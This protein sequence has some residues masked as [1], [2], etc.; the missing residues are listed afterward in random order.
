MRAD[1][2][3]VQDTTTGDI[4]Q[5]GPLPLSPGF[6][7]ARTFGDWTT[8]GRYFV[9]GW[10]NMSRPDITETVLV[11]SATLTARQIL[12][13][14]PNREVLS[15]EVSPDGRTAYIAST[16][17][18]SAM[19]DLIDLPSDRLVFTTNRFSFWPSAFL[20][21]TSAPLPPEAL[22]AQVV[23]RSVRLTWALPPMSDGASPFFLEAGSRP[24]GTD[25]R[26]QIDGAARELDLA[27][28]P[29]G[30]YFVRLRAVNATG[31]SLPTGDIVVEVS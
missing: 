12:P 1:G 23:R 2:L 17:G 9:H 20:A 19:V 3:T 31:T 15:I 27:G 21:L 30:R 18:L 10:A 29:P 6:S 24:G 25:V 4:V 16:T 13:L 5:S 11:D 7:Y 28:V 22:Q 26:M 8:G 14:P